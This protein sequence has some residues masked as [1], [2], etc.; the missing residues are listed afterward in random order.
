MGYWNQVYP[1]DLGNPEQTGGDV[2]E[3]ATSTIS[4]I[5]I[6]SPATTNGPT[7]SLLA[8]L[9]LLIAMRVL[10]DRGVSPGS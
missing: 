1:V 2:Q 8:I 10:V 7:I 5:T 4:P 9:G 6:G 3:V